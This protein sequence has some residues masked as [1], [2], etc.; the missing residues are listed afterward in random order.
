LINAYSASHSWLLIALC[1]SADAAGFITHYSFNMKR[2]ATGLLLLVSLGAAAQNEVRETVDRLVIPYVSSGHNRGL[3]V[4]VLH[5]G[6]QYFFNYGE[7]TKSSGMKPDSSSLF[8]IGTLTEVFTTTL[9]ANMS[10]EGKVQIDDPLEALMPA[11]VR[12]P[13]Y[14]RIACEPVKIID[15][16]MGSSEETYTRSNRYNCVPVSQSQSAPILLCD[17]ATHTVGLPQMKKLHLRDR[18]NPFARYTQAD[19]YRFLNT[20]EFD[21]PATFDYRPSPLDAALLGHALSLKAGM[22]YE[23]LLKQRITNRLGL[24]DTR[25]SL[26][27][28]QMERLLAGHNRKGKPAPYWNYDVLAPAGGLRSTAKDLLNFTAAQLGNLPGNWYFTLASAHNPRHPVRKKGHPDSEIGLGWLLSPIGTEGAKII[29]SEGQTGGFSA[30]LG[31]VK[32]TG[33][34]VVILSNS[35]NSVTPMGPEILAALQKL[36]VSVSK[37]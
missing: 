35:A 30:Y 24:N 37:R 20:Y 13:R 8:E 7:K 1:R 19:L 18:K 29:W 36:S 12:V 3:V 22:S 26:S 5:E 16:S 31:F 4:G 23:E 17:L 25:L 9:L 10:M 21:T 28:D 15:I 27:Y 11:S 6:R 33:I 14:V 2:F 32:E 34:G